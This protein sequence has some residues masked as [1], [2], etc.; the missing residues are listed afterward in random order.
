MNNDE[1][2][3][4]ELRKIAAWADLQ[5]K[6]TKWSFIAVA[7]AV[8]AMMVFAVVMVKREE[9]RMGVTLAP[10]KPERPTW[11]D[12]DSRIRRGDLDE[13]VRIGEELIQKTPHY[14]EGHQRLASAYLAVGKTE[15]ARQHYAEAF[16]LFPSEQNEKLLF[17]IDKRIKEG[18]PQPGGRGNS[19][20]TTPEVQSDR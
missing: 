19:H 13:A 17:A 6:I 4:I 16:D 20:P 5:R 8:P 18:N 10:P 3:L 14:S 11:S 2:I 7:V 9:A 1:P 12:V 15:Q